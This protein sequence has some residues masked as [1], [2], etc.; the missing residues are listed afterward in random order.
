M[1]EQPM[2]GC[3]IPQ[4]WQEKLEAIAANTGRQATQIV[5]EAIAQYLAETDIGTLAGQLREVKHRLE[6]VEK[7]MGQADVLAEQIIALSARLV[8]LEDTTDSPQ[9]LPT[10]FATNIYHTNAVSVAEHQAIVDA[11]A[12][13]E[14]VE[15]EPDEILYDFLEKPL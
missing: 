4:E 11:I 8:A 15:D 6:Q 2:V 14:E 10:Q 1:A 12:G 13:L 5:Y 3:Q 9:A 7:R